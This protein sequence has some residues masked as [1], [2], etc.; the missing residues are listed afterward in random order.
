MHK[1]HVLKEGMRAGDLSDMILPLVSVDE[2]ESKIDDDAIVIGFYVSDHD[3][4]ED[5]NRFIQ[6]SPVDLLDSEISPAPDQNGNFMVFVEIMN[7]RS[8][9]DNVMHIVSEIAPLCSIDSWQMQVRGLD[10]VTDLEADDLAAAL[11]KNDDYDS[12]HGKPSVKEGILL[13]LHDSQLENA[14]VIVK[15]DVARIFLEGRAGRLAFEVVAFGDHDTIMND[16]NLSECAVDLSKG[17]LSRSAAVQNIL[18]SHWDVASLT[19]H[20]IILHN[21]TNDSCLLVK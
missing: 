19:G 1:F 5:L 20:G 10:A 7:N 4:A 2:F 8:I 18:G 15:N 3:A 17:G 14:Q 9:V 6:R 12:D 13:A 16:E 21:L 11:K